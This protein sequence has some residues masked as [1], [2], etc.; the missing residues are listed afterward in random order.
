MCDITIDVI[1]LSCETMVILI[2]IAHKNNVNS[3]IHQY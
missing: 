1:T 2:V 3:D